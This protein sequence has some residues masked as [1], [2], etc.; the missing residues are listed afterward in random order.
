MGKLGSARFK[1]LSPAEQSKYQIQYENAKK[2]YEKDLAAF[3]ASGGEM[4]AIQTQKRKEEGMKVTDPNKPKKPAGGAYGC[5]VAKH[6]AAFQKECAGKPV[7][8]VAKLAGE[9]W[10]SLSDAEKKPFEKEYQ[11]KKAA[12]EAAM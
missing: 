2:Q 12:Y 10:K 3:K 9:R 1:A 8:A 7:T 5:Y 6:R 4:K 11:E